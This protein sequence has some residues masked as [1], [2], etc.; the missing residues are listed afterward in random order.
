MKSVYIA[1][2]I[3]AALAGG[4]CSAPEAS[5][6]KPPQPV[7]VHV[8]AQAEPQHG[9][10]YSASI[11]PFDQVTVSFKASGY[12]EQVARRRGADGRD[13]LVQQGDPVARGTVLARVQTSDNR[14]RVNQ[15]RA[16]LDEAAAS[17][18]KARLDLDRMRTLFAAES[19]TKPELDGAQAAFDA[20]QARI[21]AARADVELAESALR[22]SELVAPSSGVVLDR[23]VEVGS[24]AGV[25]TVAFVIANV[26]SVKARFGIPDAMIHSVHMGD[27][28]DVSVEGAARPSFSGRVTAIAPVADAQSRVF[29]VEITI[30]NGDGVLRPGM[31]GTVIVNQQPGVVAAERALSVP[32]TAVVRASGLGSSGFALVAVEG[33]GQGTVARLRPVELGEVSGNAIEVRSGVQAGTRVVVSGASLLTDGAPVRVVT[34]SN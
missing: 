30:A 29:D 8:V 4:A 21:A 20:A 33:D 23:K 16:R 32:L 19:A 17:G 26:S 27:G 13:R 18:V 15:G 2:V 10:H 14:E 1:A 3:G 11:E 9:V 7:N 22:D 31:I 6:P 28:L 12:V 5:A 25:G 24:L 34:G